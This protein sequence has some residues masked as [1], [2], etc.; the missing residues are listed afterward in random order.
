MTETELI[1]RLIVTTEFRE[2]QTVG[3]KIHDN[4]R[5]FDLLTVYKELIDEMAWSRLFA[6][7][8]DST[9]NHGLDQSVFRKLLQ[10]I[11]DLKR[12]LKS[13]P[14]EEDTKTICIT[15]W[16]TE[17]SRRVD[18]LIKIIDVKGNIKAVVGIENK[19]DSGEQNDQIRDYQKSLIIAFPRVSKVLLYLTPDGR[20]TETGDDN[21]QC[22]CLSVSYDTISAV[23]EQTSP[24]TNGQGQIFLSV[25]K[26]H[27]DKLTNNKIMD[28]DALQ[29]IRKLYKDPE[30]RQA[31]KLISQYS[32]NIRS[33]FDD[34]TL[35]LNNSKSL[36]F[37]MEK[38]SIDYY[39]KTSPNPH[40]LKIYIDDLIEIGHKKGFNPCYM[41]HC[42]NPNPDFGD[43]FTL[44]IAIWYSNFKGRDAAS[45]QA[46]REKIQNAFTFKN[47]LGTNKHWSQW[48]CVW[49]GNSY[50]LTDM[51]DNDVEGLKALLIN[52][53]KATYQDYKTGLKKLAKSRL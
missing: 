43:I 11:P 35:K 51:G 32:P 38:A 26:N 16:K 39:P 1:N 53:I 7:L 46:I 37:S 45:R 28:K 12:F 47:S 24:S 30:H 23:C 44:R 13:L 25:L 48:I 18:I 9:Q 3:L 10:Q 14:T 19:V 5:Q 33:V 34:L 49:T 29:L 6:Y 20:L 40:E 2:L 4:Q 52:G 22:P 42:E 50:K 31:I 21:I 27:I 15:E 8:L 41:L 17:N 36:Q